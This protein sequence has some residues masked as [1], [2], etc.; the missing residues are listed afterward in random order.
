[1]CGKVHK[2]GR[3]RHLPISAATYATARWAHG[4]YSNRV[5]SPG[6]T[7][8]MSFRGTFSPMSRANLRLRGE[9]MDDSSRASLQGLN[10]LVGDWRTEATHPMY[11]STVVHGHSM[12][13]WLQGER[14]LIVRALSDHPDFP[15]SISII[16]DTDGLRMHYFDSRG[17]HRV[18][19][20]NV[21]AEAWEFSRDA[22][23][24]SQR[25]TGTFEDG[26]DTISG[27]SKLSRDDITW[28]DDLQIT[29]RRS[30]SS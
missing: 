7:M 9:R 14:F 8:R 5:S 17:V 6:S 20:V 3:T 1:M 24:F 29:Y 11:P 22:P 28:E 15:D 2:S 18:Y 19:E 27:L 26:G 16:G 23:G 4:G 10:A 13:E 25:F 12:F 30:T 21:S